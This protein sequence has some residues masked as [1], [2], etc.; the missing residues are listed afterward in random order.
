MNSVKKTPLDLLNEIYSLAYWMTGSEID[1]HNLV[2]LTYDHANTKTNEDELLKT[3]RECYLERFG[4]N[5]N[6]CINNKPCQTDKQLNES[7]KHWG[8]DI[9]LSTLLSE[10]SGLKHR[11]IS[12][13]VGKPLETIRMWLLWGRKLLIDCKPFYPIT[14]QAS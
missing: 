8:A 12:K 1:S 13:I 7:L 9:K 11:Q 14:L 6:L 10:I 2:Q 4:Q 5:T 3:F